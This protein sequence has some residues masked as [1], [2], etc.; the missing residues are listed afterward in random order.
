MI[1]HHD[2]GVELDSRESGLPGQQFLVN[3]PSEQRPILKQQLAAVGADRDEVRAGRSVIEGGKA[4]RAAA[5][6]FVGHSK[7]ERWPG[8]SFE[9]PGGVMPRCL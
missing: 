8:V 5:G 4:Y 7:R 1:G 6:V 2:K 3:Q 9:D